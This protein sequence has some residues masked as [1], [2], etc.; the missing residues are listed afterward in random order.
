MTQQRPVK[1]AL[2]VRVRG[3]EGGSKSLHSYD[4]GQPDRWEDDA[5]AQEE[6]ELQTGWYGRVSQ[7][8]LTK[9]VAC[10][11]RPVHHHQSL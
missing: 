4:D 11:D 7:P 2:H 9:I 6:E 3:T 5:T 10:F 1:A 8:Q